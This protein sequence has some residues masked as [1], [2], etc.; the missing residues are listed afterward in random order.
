MT[1]RA[2]IAAICG[3]HSAEK[4]LLLHDFIK[5]RRREGLRLAGVIEARDPGAGACGALSLI[6]LAT[7]A[8]IS[9]SQKLGPGST[10]CNLD[11]GGVAD[12][13]AAAQRAIAAGADLVALSKFGKLEADGGGLRD[14]FA[15]A[16]ESGLPVI[17]TLHPS[18]REDFF[19]FAGDLAEA[20]APEPQALDAWWSELFA[21]SRAA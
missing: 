16:G 11:P 9:I 5:R 15:S 3:A 10:A 21:Q 2:A 4:R 1:S 12:A 20:I 13:C 17:T 8:R 7:G 14:A 6:D 18:L 19:R